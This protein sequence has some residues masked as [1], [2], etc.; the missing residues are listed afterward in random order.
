LCYGG[1]CPRNLESVTGAPQ[2]IQ[3][4]LPRFVELS[5]WAICEYDVS[6]EPD[7]G[8]K[9]F[10]KM[11]S[12]DELRARRHADAKIGELAWSS[13]VSAGPERRLDIAGNANPAKSI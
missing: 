1:G 4:A 5:N 2:D 12:G 6:L 3:L 10:S 9:I 13:G 11:S 7:G 8:R